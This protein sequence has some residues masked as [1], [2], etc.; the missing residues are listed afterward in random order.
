MIWEAKFCTM[1]LKELM[2]K[3]KVNIVCG[4][5]VNQEGQT[6]FAATCVQN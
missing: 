5:L 1:K 4:E 3:D 6:Q 2:R